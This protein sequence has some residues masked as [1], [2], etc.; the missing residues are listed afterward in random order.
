MKIGICAPSAAFSRDD[1][2]RVL[3]L[4]A[5]EYPHAQLVFHDQ[6]FFEAGHFAGTDVQRSKAFVELANDPSIDAIWYARGGYGAGRIA[7]DAVQQLGDAA[8]DKVYLGYSDGGFLLSALYRDG[9][10]R[11]THGPVVA[12]IRRTGGTAAVRRALDFLVAGK[13]AAIEPHVEPGQN[14]AAFN[15]MTLAMIVGTPLLPDLRD[16]VLMIEEVSEYLYAFDRAMF[17]VTT[18]LKATGITGIRLGRVLD[19]PENDRPFGEDAEQIARRWC[20]KNG[21]A[22]LGAADIGHDSENK[23]VPFGR[24]Y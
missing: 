2:D 16:H 4:A 6:C 5:E 12:D 8:H 11:P 21:I 3:A 9:I 14:Y 15:L 13:S 7:E 24:A 19:I 17:N 10:G 23:I 20:D 18:H 22:F 1:A